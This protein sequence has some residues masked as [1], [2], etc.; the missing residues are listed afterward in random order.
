[1]EGVK[2]GMQSSR[3]ITRSQ[4]LPAT[5]VPPS[6]GLLHHSRPTTHEVP[7]WFQI[8][9]SGTSRYLVSSSLFL[10]HSISPL[11]ADD[12]RPPQNPTTFNAELS[13]L[14]HSHSPR[15]SLPRL[16]QDHL[17]DRNSYSVFLTSRTPT[18][19]GALYSIICI[20]HV[21]ITRIRIATALEVDRTGLF[22]S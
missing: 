14:T 6:L 21:A 17:S 10:S 1:M 4:I 18:C 20:Y 15:P 5:H 7:F 12:R 2:K 16:H 3:W 22:Q 19:A 13:T 9:T 11:Y 8:S